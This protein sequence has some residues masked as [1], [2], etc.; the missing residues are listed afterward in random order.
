MPGLPRSTALRL[1][2]LVVLV[3]PTLVVIAVSLAASSG[4]SSPVA[5][6]ASSDGDS[7]DVRG[8]DTSKKI[9]ATPGPLDAKPGPLDAKLPW[10]DARIDVRFEVFMPIA[11]DAIPLAKGAGAG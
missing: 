6:D 2:A 4:L 9:D 10:S 5:K 7:A 8:S 3:P 11:P 1:R